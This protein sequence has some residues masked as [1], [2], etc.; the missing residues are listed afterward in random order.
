M[1][2]SLSGITEKHM[3][4]LSLVVAQVGKALGCWTEGQAS[5]MAKLLV[6]DF[7]PLCFRA[8]SKDMWRKNWEYF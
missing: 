5:S 7:N 3:V 6:Q 2:Y 8:S 1:I 4:L